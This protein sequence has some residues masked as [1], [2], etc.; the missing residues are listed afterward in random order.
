M[1]FAKLCSVQ[2]IKKKSK[3]RIIF[4]M[5]CHFFTYPVKKKA[6]F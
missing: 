1:V 5:N 4:D 6:E 2:I 3:R